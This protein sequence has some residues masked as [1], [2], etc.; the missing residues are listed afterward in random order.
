M[1]HKLKKVY[2]ILV[3]L[4]FENFEH[5]CQTP[6]TFY[7]SFEDA[8]LQMLRMIE[9]MEYAPTQL[10]IATLWKPIKN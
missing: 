10:K 3:A 6:Q 8:E 1:G 7:E 9:N 4:D 2:A 5:Y